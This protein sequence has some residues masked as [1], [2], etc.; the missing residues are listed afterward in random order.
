[1]KFDET[2]KLVRVAG[3]HVYRSAVTVTVTVTVL[4]FY[5]LRF[6]AARAAAL[7]SH[8]PRDI[9]DHS[10]PYAPRPPSPPPVSSFPILPLR[11]RTPSRSIAIRMGESR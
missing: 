9:S 11:H 4:D 6:M 7:P 3:H 2:Q 1:M 8:L 5:L 10:P